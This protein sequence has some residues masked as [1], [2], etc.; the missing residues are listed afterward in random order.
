MRKNATVLSSSGEE[1]SIEDSF[2]SELGDV[3][4]LY[5]R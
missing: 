2:K 3:I 1:P 4:L 5:V